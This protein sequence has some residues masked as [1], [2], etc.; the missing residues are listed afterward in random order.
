MINEKAEL[1]KLPAVDKLLNEP[2]IQQAIKETNEN[3]V[4]FSIRETI[5][6]YR[7]RILN[8]NKLPDYKIIISDI[9]SN[10]N[11][12]TNRSLK[13][14]INA[15]GVVVHT[16]LGR[17]PLGEDLLKESFETLKSYNNLE[18]DLEKGKRG[19]RNNHAAGLLKF[20]TGAEDVVVV[21]NNAA[22]VMFILSSFA[23]NKEAIISRGEL[24]EIGGAFR[25]PDIMESS[26]AKMVEVGTTNKTKIQDYENAISENTGLIFK[27]HKSNYVIKGFTKEATLDEIVS[28]GRKYNIPTVYDI[29]SGLLRK[30]DN[31]ALKSEPD[32]KQ[33]IKKGIDI[34]CFSG[35]KL[36]GGPQAGIIAGKKKFISKLKN[37]PL[38]RVLRVGKTTL[39]LLETACKYYLNDDDLFTKNILFKTLK[40]T[41]E[42]KRNTAEKLK[43]LLISKGVNTE[44]IENKG[45][46]GGGTL[47]EYTIDSFAL[48]IIFD[49]N[50]QQTNSEKLFKMLLLQNEPVLGILRQGR[51]YFDIL[52]IFDDDIEKLAQLIH[53]SYIKVI[54]E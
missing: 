41:I 39:T 7:N 49:G 8:N 32:V 17:A 12:L 27:T 25:I 29:G 18:F 2:E 22:A 4:K 46:Y 19:H 33:A 34:V 20:L 28:L 42:E 45:R 13:P 52:T 10:V 35:D 43:N 54:S 11:K 37:H 23:K 30:V 24:I 5:S 9:I 21:N 26:G 3:I 16:N 6:K 48:K 1:K 14:V 40:R 50:Y 36:L 51:I 31:E 38:M 53:E 44:I 47:P 15:T